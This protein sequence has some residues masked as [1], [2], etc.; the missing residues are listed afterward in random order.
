MT[1]SDSR[2]QQNSLSVLFYYN[3]SNLG[4]LIDKTFALAQFLVCSELAKGGDRRFA[5]HDKKRTDQIQLDTGRVDISPRRG[6]RA[7]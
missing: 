3:N 1:N 5:G 6:G 4:F 2:I 7:R